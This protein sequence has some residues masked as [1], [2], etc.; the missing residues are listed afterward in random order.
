M[1]RH[2][3]Q[4]STKTM[5]AHEY[6]GDTDGTP[7]VDTANLSVPWTVGPPAAGV[8]LAGARCLAS[9]PFGA[10]HRRLHS[11]LSWSACRA[12]SAEVARLDTN[13][14]R[15]RLSKGS[16]SAT[17]R[18]EASTFNRALTKRA[19]AETVDWTKGS[20]GRSGA[21]NPESSTLLL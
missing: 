4:F 20:D 3:K 11:G 21:R 14:L 6:H 9:I 8:V 16:P 18:P 2:T 17:K 12:T 1:S 7:T 5:Q 19:S 10:R 13:C 15:N